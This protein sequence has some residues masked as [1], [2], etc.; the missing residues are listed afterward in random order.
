MIALIGRIFH[1]SPIFLGLAVLLALGSPAS[2]AQRNLAL[3]SAASEKR[4]ALVIGNAAYPRGALNNPVN[5]ANDMAAVLENL[6]FT[7]ILRTNVDRRGMLEATQAF[8][9]RLA[10]GGVGF[11]YFAGHG[12]QSEGRNYLVPLDAQLHHESDLEF[13]A[14]DAN[15]VLVSMSRSGSR[16]SIVVLDACRDN[17]FLRSSRSLSRGLVPLDLASGSFLAY[18]TSPGSVAADGKGRNGLYTRHLLDSLRQSDT[19]LEEVF[20]R[21]RVAVARETDGRQIPWDAS[22]ILGE[23]HFRAPTAAIALPLREPGDDDRALWD[24]VR[25][26]RNVDE[27]SAY[28][29]RFPA[30]LF[31]DVARARIAN[32]PATPAPATP[33]APTAMA[34]TLTAHQQAQL[35]FAHATGSGGR[36]QDDVEAVRLFKL[37]AAQRNALGQTYLGMMYSKGR[38]GLPRDE[39]E[40][41]RLHQL[42]AAQ[43]NAL[44][45]ANLGSMYAIGSG[46]V[47][48]DDVQA[49]ELFISSAAQGSPFGQALLGQ[50]YA[51]GRVGGAK[52][53]RE[54]VRLFRL[55][56]SQGNALGQAGLGRMYAEGRGGLDRNDGEALRLYMLSAE[57]GEP[58]GQF[59]LGEL[60]ESGRTQEGRDGGTAAQWYRRAADQGHPQAPAALRRLLRE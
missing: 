60:Y 8:G 40:A 39:R 59:G 3:D 18:A 55:S 35:G 16:V 22:S 36:H 29:R 23:F 12:I 43:G 53:Y 28:L 34:G 17:P 44:G 26:S 45:Q 1:G 57:Q 38:G 31:A 24:A 32:S 15:R 4:V 11:F 56:A 50:M 48:R 37:S 7:V 20:K 21:V 6:G 49:I 14:V 33:V 9:A 13:E 42:S 54:A 27:L 46:G 47:P 41:L 10:R 30:G 52:D 5:D 58:A 25:D 2:V 19:R 51:S